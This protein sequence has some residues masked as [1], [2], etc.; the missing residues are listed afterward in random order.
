M[1]ELYCIRITAYFYPQVFIICCNAK[2][3]FINVVFILTHWVSKL[4]ANTFLFFLNVPKHIKKIQKNML[5][6]IWLP[7]Q[8]LYTFRT[9][10]VVDQ[11]PRYEMVKLKVQVKKVWSWLIHCS[12]YCFF[13]I[14]FKP[15]TTKVEAKINKTEKKLCS[16]WFSSKILNY[17]NIFPDPLFCWKIVKALATNIVINIMEAKLNLNNPQFAKY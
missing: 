11:N 16:N 2:I 8:P 9:S 1:M 14:Y 15:D 13:L 6:I 4:T 5:N 3:F 10:I 12:Y 7:D 17:S